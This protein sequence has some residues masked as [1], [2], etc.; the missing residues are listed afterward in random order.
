MSP[1]EIEENV[2]K[3]KELLKSDDFDVVNT[4]LEL[5]RSLDEDAVYEKLLEGC[6]VDKEGKLVNEK[7][8]LSDYLV[9]SL[10]S[11]SN[12]P[13]AKEILDNVTKLDLRW[14]ESITNVDGLANLANLTYLHL[15][16]C[17]SLTNLNVSPEE[18]FSLSSGATWNNIIYGNPITK[19]CCNNCNH[20]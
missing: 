15:G 18:A 7:K 8:E 20:E 14:D 19:K 9:C 1:S 17:K 5:A 16:G 2:N 13:K 6:G 3:I 11:V 12:G 4:G 10:A